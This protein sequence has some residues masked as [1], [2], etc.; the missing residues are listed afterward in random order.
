MGEPVSGLVQPRF[1]ATIRHDWEK[2]EVMDD[3]NVLM[4]IKQIKKSF[5]GVLALND[6]SFCINRGEIHAL[7]GENG[8]GKSTLI[9]ILSGVY[10]PDEGEIIF[11]DEPYKE[12]S[13]HYSK[14]RG[15]ETIYQEPALARDLTVAENLYLDHLPVN[16]WGLMDY[17]K[18]F[19]DAE[20][21][22]GE[23]G[24]CLN[25]HARVDELRLPEIQLITI[26]RCM[27]HNSKMIIMDEPSSSLS[28]EELRVLFR[29]IN[30]LKSKGV[31]I[32]YITHNISDVMSIAD[33]ATVLRDGEV[34]G[35]V[36]VRE[37]VENDIVS[38]MIGKQF[39][40]NNQLRHENKDYT[41]AEK[42]M[43]V[44][45]F[46]SNK[47][48]IQEISFDLY[49]G[50]ILGFYG[51]VGSGRTELMQLIFGIEK[52]DK[53]ELTVCGSPVEIKNPCDAVKLKMGFVPEDRLKCG[54][55]GEMTVRENISIA[56]L[57]R[58]KKLLL[59]DKT[60]EKKRVEDI[61][62]ALRIKAPSMEQQILYLSGGN[63]QKCIIGRWLI[64]D[65]DILIMDEP[66]RG[67]DVGAKGEI[68]DILQK[69]VED[70]ISVIMISSD[71][72]E[73][74]ELCDRVYVLNKGT[75][76]QPFTKEQI[77]KDTIIRTALGV[78]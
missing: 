67:I 71:I 58:I 48:K 9:K 22:V 49:K 60:M 36:N 12:Y 47:L 27:I 64:K 30:D 24:A 68:Y 76:S 72:E 32:I 55:F 43:Q 38:M 66:T 14:A 44:R 15:L 8:A 56:F 41:E 40:R 45:S 75:I 65:I 6:V 2:R 28:Y 11:D 34:V 61:C 74:I 17:P 51:L 13:I 62:K 1:P 31:S 7:V 59:L 19:N 77:N 50:E 39:V 78:Q 46:S 20:Q 54:I 73:I 70:G 29:I 35:T 63:K 3:N 23:L 52:P 33:R 4:E 10:A 21:M 69:L 37:T 53:G 25:V 26:L 42:I 16:R 57:D 18:L 5:P